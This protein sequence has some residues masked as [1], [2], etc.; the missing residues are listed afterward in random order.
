MWQHLDEYAFCDG[1]AIPFLYMRVQ[2]VKNEKDLGGMGVGETDVT[3]LFPLNAFDLQVLGC[4]WTCILKA[5]SPVV[6]ERSASA[7]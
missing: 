5:V 1:T 7:A 6:Y 3:P 4:R 2:Q